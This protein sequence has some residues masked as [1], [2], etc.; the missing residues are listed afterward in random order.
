MT[1]LGYSLDSNTVYT[2]EG[3]VGGGSGY[4]NIMT[5]SISE[6]GTMGIITP[7]MLWEK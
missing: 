3:N 5:R 1:I 6:I 7:G 4:T 2:I